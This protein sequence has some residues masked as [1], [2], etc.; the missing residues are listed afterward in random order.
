MIY[1]GINDG[2]NY[3]IRGSKFFDYKSNFIESGVTQNNLTKNDIKIVVP[4]NYF[5]NFWRSLNMPLINWEIELI[6]TRFENC[7]LISKA[8]RGVDYDVSTVAHKINN[9]ENAVFQI[10][11]TKLYV[12][13]VT[14]SKKKKM[15]QNF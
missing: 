4:L 10:T 5:S 15:T 11:D 3:W 14:L 6:L 8:T 12:P 7:V 13:V 9:P 2:I 1:D